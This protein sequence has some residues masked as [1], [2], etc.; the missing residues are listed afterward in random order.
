MKTFND[1][2]IGD[3]LYTNDFK[4][5]KLRIISIIKYNFINKICFFFEGIHQ[6]FNYT[7]SYYIDKDYIVCTD[8]T[9]LDMLNEL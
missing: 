9:I 8:L 4:N 5:P 7:D 3:I 6:T 1:C 2:K